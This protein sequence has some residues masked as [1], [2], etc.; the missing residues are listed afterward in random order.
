MSAFTGSLDVRHLDADWRIWELIEPL[1]YEVGYLGSGRTIIVP[2]GF[3]TDGASVPRF[4]WWCLSPTGPWLRAAALHDFLC[5][6]I[7]AGAPHPE[8]PTRRA[9]DAV[10]LEAMAVL[11]VPRLV[12]TLMWAAV[13]A[14]SILAA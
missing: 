5:R 7:A 2:V 13:R 4:L 3:Q 8:A 10:F 9:A 6:S 11:G 12:R 1:V 14:Y